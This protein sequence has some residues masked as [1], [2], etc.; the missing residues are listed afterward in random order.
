[1]KTVKQIGAS[2]QISLGKEF[3]GRTVVVDSREPGV[4]VIKTAQT[5]PDSELWLH[6]PESAARLDRAMAAMDQPPI[7]ADLDALEQHL[8]ML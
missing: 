6:Q 7:S 5:I 1:M 8:G 2:G 3:A 4:W